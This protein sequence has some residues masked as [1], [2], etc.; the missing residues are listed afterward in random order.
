VSAGYVIILRYN[1]F[2]VEA[3]IVCHISHYSF[4]IVTCL[5]IIRVPAKNDTAAGIDEEIYPLPA[6][7]IYND[8]PV[9]IFAGLYY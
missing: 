3:S 6:G 1:I 4:F 7:R 9:Y 5:F 2:R 8:I